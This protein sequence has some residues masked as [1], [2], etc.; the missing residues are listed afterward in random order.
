[1]AGRARIGERNVTVQ[2]VRRSLASPAPGSSEPRHPYAVLFTTRAKVKT[3]SGLSEF[4]RVEIG[5]RQVT[6]TFGI[7]FTTIPF[8]TRDRVRDVGG[9]LYQILRV[10]DVDEQGHELAL[11][12]AAVG[13]ETVE[14]AR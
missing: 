12:C 11:R 7:R 10:D 6:H 1:M 3:H 5:G 9:R 8:D 13:S 2:I 14:A 4:A